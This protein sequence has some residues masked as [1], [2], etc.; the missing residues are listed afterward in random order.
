MFAMTSNNWEDTRNNKESVSVRLFKKAPF[1]KNAVDVRLGNSQ[2]TPFVE[3]YE[4]YV[5]NKRI[6]GLQSRTASLLSFLIYNWLLKEQ[7]LFG[8]NSF[9]ETEITSQ[10]LKDLYD[11]NCFC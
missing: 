5:I 10:M 1:N 2:K 9:Y 3:I 8:I 6:T 11:I 4:V 7:H